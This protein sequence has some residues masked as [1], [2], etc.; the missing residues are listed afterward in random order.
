MMEDSETTVESIVKYVIEWVDKRYKDDE[1]LSIA[2]FTVNHCLQNYIPGRVLPYIMRSVYNALQNYKD[3][4]INPLPPDILDDKHRP[5]SIPYEILNDLE[6]ATI[7]LRYEMDM[8]INEIAKK[9]DLTYTQARY[10]LHTAH[11][12]LRFWYERWK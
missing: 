1:A 5:W 9:L 3:N 7:T 12:K 10:K 8:N 4:N 6:E 2:I 11:N